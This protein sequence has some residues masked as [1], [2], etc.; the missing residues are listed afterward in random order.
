MIGNGTEHPR[1]LPTPG[2]ADARLPLGVAY[3]LWAQTA[4]TCIPILLFITPAVGKGL[5]TLS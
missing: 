3:G 1:K 2:D 4:H 5:W